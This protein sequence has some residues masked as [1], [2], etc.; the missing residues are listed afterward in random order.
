M[1]LETAILR[2]PG[3]GAGVIVTSGSAPELLAIDIRDHR[4]D[5]ASIRSGQR[6]FYRTPGEHEVGFSNLERK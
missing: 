5:I 2:R 3:S 1:G 6:E 4:E